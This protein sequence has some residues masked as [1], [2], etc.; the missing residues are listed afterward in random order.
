M[1]EFKTTCHLCDKDII[2]RPFD[3]GT[4]PMFNLDGAIHEHKTIRVSQILSEIHYKDDEDKTKTIGDMT[5]SELEDRIK[6]ISSQEAAKKLGAYLHSIHGFISKG[7]KED[8][9][10]KKSSLMKMSII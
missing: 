5:I 6:R 9:I 4:W 2:R 8:F 10:K 1:G 7:F 3:D